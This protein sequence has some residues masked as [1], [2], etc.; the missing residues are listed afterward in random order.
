MYPAMNYGNFHRSYEREYYRHCPH[1]RDRE[2]REEIGQME[3][4]EDKKDEDKR[5]SGNRRSQRF[6]TL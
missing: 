4:V 3:E 2:S 5:T 6:N 1:P